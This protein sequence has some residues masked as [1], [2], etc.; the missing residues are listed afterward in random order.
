M[1]LC[2]AQRS[3]ADAAAQRRTAAGQDRRATGR[4]QECTP[5]HRLIFQ[6]TECRLYYRL[7]SKSASGLPIA[8]RNACSPSWPNRSS[9]AATISGA[10]AVTIRARNPRIHSLSCDFIM[11]AMA[12]AGLGGFMVDMPS[13]TVP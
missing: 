9:I 4:Y 13:C 10:L 11:D 1:E 8:P 6:G 7:V 5:A 2:E 12:T 3:G